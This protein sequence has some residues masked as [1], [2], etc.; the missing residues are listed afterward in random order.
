VT[1]LG[2]PASFVFL[3]GRPRLLCVEAILIGDVSREFVALPNMIEGS[4]E[5]EFSFTGVSQ[6]ICE[7]LAFSGLMA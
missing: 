7:V 2:R 6:V 3:F 5:N 4:G 1:F